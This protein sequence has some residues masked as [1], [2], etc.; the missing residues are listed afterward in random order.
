M[1]NSYLTYLLGLHFKDRKWEHVLARPL[2]T[3]CMA[4]AAQWWQTDKPFPCIVPTLCTV[5]T[6]SP[7]SASSCSVLDLFSCLV[8]PA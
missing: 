5:P 8:V 2:P 7:P 3:G 1:D 4:Q 6:P